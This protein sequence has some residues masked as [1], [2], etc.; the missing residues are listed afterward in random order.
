ME[1]NQHTVVD[2]DDPSTAVRNFMGEFHG[3]TIT[4]T[5]GRQRMKSLK[6]M[7]KKRFKRKITYFGMDT[8]T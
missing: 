4:E 5:D 7:E 3:V 2:N 8:A 6:M 1:K